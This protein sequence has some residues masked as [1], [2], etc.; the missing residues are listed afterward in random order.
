MEIKV[1]EQINERYLYCVRGE[2]TTRTSRV[3]ITALIV[4]YSSEEAFNV[5]KQRT[6][7]RVKI[8]E[9]SKT[10]SVKENISGCINYYELRMEK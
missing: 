1:M 3:Y 7:K 5:F 8:T 4:A 2:T 6:P 10:V 9:C